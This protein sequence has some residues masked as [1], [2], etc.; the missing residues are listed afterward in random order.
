MVAFIAVT[1]LLQC[2]LAHVCD[3]HHLLT[4][5]SLFDPSEISAKES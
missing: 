1:S 2:P 5:T 4:S 3:S